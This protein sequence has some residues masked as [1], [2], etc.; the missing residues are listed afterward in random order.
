MVRVWVRVIVG[1]MV[2]VWVGLVRGYR[3]DVSLGLGLRLG[4]VWG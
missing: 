1:P 4:L 3:F 2:W